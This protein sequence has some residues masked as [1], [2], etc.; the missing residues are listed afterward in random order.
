MLGNYLKTAV[1][2]LLRHKV[3]TGINVV[4]LATGMACTMLILLWV[5]DEMRFDRFNTH[6]SEIYRI[7]HGKDHVQQRTAGTPA[8]LGPAIREEIPE[9]A[10]FARIAPASPKI[11]VQSGE[12]MFY[13]S[14]MMFADPALFEMF[15]FPFV[16][17][18]PSNAL[19]GLSNVVITEEIARKY[20][21]GEDP[22]GKTLTLEGVD[23]IV[24]SG[25]VMNIPSESHLQFD[26]VLPFD[27]VYAY[28]LLGTEWGDFNY[29]TYIQL[30]PH[31]F[32]PGL[33]KAITN[34]ARLHGCPQVV[35]GGYECLLQPL[36]EVHLGGSVERSGVD[37]VSEP[38][39]RTTV[40]M[41]SLIAVFILGIACINFMNLSTAQSDARRREVSVRKALGAQRRQLVAQFLGESVMLSGLACVIAVIL[42]E[43]FLPA[44]NRLTMKHVALSLSDGAMVLELVMIGLLTGLVAGSYPAFYLSSFLPAALFKKP[45]L[46]PSASWRSITRGM[47]RLSFRKVLVVMQFSLS[48]GLIICTLVIARQLEFMKTKDLGFDRDNVLV[49]PIKEHFGS[50]YEAIKQQLLQHPAILGVAAQEWFQ[51]RGPRNTGGRGYSWAGNPDPDHSPWISHT[52]VDCGFI[53]LMGI[54]MLE[55][56]SFSKDH[57]T[58]AKDAFIVNEEAVRAMGLKSPVGKYFRLYGQ[59]GQIIGVMQNACFSSLRQSVEPLVY[60]VLTSADDARYGAIL[61][62]LQSGKTAEGI[63]IIED[64]WKREN[65]HSPFDFQF[66]DDAVNSRYMSESRTGMI[67]SWFASLAIFISCLGLFGL[68]SFAAEQRTKEI[69]IRKVLGSSV[70]SIVI[71][72]SK[73]FTSWVIVANVIAWPIAWYAMNAWLQRFAY[74]IGASWWVF[75]LAG[76]IALVI[77]LL[78]I[79]YQ[80][81]RA[82]MANPVEALRYE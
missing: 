70:A 71:L 13:E 29:S 26:F 81:V 49:V 9:V 37:V 66:L 33:D 61:V 47:Q 51:I 73:E 44:F 62:K 82:A 48:I 34:V 72:L 50:S 17:G 69:G 80:A 64:L 74:R 75:V 2:H 11:V 8:P 54:R 67:F 19:S 27:D 21:G 31:S 14:R 76:G 45:A 52:R 39:E 24:V 10:Q 15:T 12:K 6:A 42:V 56:R 43:V 53:E 58:D 38:G 65:P 55:G 23:H 46:S 40:L 68:A 59:E 18:S 60:H 77:A 35:Y 3:Y 78:T 28:H 4:G 41:F 57:P 22:M 1:R 25:V 5:Q 16:K 30:R 7:L 63:A 20:F 32:H 79:S 36:T